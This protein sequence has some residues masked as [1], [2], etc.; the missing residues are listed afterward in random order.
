MKKPK[1]SP[2]G[3]MLVNRLSV[4]DARHLLKHEG[5]EATPLE[6]ALQAGLIVI[7]AWLSARAILREGATVWDLLLPGFAQF[8]ALLIFIPLLQ[9]WYR[10]RGMKREVIKCLGNLVFW[11]VVAA[12]AVA[13]R[14]GKQQIGWTDQLSRDTAWLMASTRERGMLWPMISASLGLVSSLPARFRALRD[15]GPPFVAISFG[16]AARALI[17]FGGFFVFP[18]LVDHPERAPWFL[19]AAML[20]ADLVALHAI[21]DIRRRIRKLDEEKTAAE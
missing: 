5:G 10:L 2:A 19:W 8:L 15:H 20:V 6:Y 9:A 18:L 14:A 4:K 16:C 3:P 11:G 13:I 1:K 17:L 7:T 21:R 12:V